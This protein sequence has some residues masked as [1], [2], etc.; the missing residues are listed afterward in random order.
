MSE[1]F[2]KRGH[3]QSKLNRVEED[4]EEEGVAKAATCRGYC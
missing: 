4:C 3:Y 1:K 2:V